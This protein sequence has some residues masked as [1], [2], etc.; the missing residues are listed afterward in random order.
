MICLRNKENIHCRDVIKLAKFVETSSFCNC[1]ATD[2]GEVVVNFDYVRFKVF[3]KRRNVKLPVIFAINF[4]LVGLRCCLFWP[5]TVLFHAFSSIWFECCWYLDDSMAILMAFQTPEVE[6]LG[7]T[8]IFGNATT[9][10]AT[11]NAL[12]LV[13]NV[14]FMQNFI[15]LM[16]Y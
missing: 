14:S 11:R 15:T 8:T 9:K 7:L 3:P 2:L 1:V 12:I 10:A 13:C 4:D 16:F 5:I 6:I